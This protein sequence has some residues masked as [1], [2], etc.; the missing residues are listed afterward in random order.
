MDVRSQL[1]VPF[2]ISGDSCE[3]PSG[4]IHADLGAWQR[5]V[6]QPFQEREQT[7]EMERLRVFQYRR[8]PAARGLGRP[9]QI[10][11]KMG[12]VGGKGVEDLSR[13]ESPP[14]RS[15]WTE[16]D[17][18]VVEGL[19]EEWR[20]HAVKRGQPRPSCPRRASVHDDT[21]LNATL[22]EQFLHVPVTQGKAVVRPDDVLDDGHREASG[23]ASSCGQAWSTG[24]QACPGAL[25][26]SRTLL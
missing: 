25:F 19:V 22:V 8:V 7:A 26:W 5:A 18:P 17:A 10:K 12:V 1:S 20:P 14:A 21:D 15:E 13:Y 24:D 3:D 16:L 6:L 9:D 2:C 23:Q 4:Q 11:M